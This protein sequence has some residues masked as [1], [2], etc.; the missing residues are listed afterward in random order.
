MRNSTYAPFTLQAVHPA[1]ISFTRQ[2]NHPQMAPFW[3]SYSHYRRMA[4][5]WAEFFNSRMTVLK[6]VTEKQP[7]L[8]QLTFGSHRM[9]MWGNDQYLN[10]PYVAVLLRKTTESQPYVH[11]GPH[12]VLWLP[13][14]SAHGTKIR[15]GNFKLCV[16]H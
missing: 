4:T 8:S 10:S 14:S 9:N 5:D 1:V 6:M 3:P 13:Y 16:H 2:R 12:Q 15:G 11:R 7:P